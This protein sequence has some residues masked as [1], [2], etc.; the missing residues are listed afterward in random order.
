M[1]PYNQSFLYTN[2]ISHTKSK[3]SGLF[4]AAKSVKW[5]LIFANRILQIKSIYIIFA[6]H[7]YHDYTYD[8]AMQ[9]RFSPFIYHVSLFIHWM[10]TQ[11]NG[12]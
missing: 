9:S 6:Y 8:Y 2:F 3:K 1:R 11:A 12:R 4:H 5:L 10:K 7:E